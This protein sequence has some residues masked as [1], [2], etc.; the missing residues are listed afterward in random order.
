M[1][2]YAPRPSSTPFTIEE[3][4]SSV[5]ISEE[6]SFA[7]SVPLP[8]ATPVFAS[9]RAGLSFTPSPVT[10]TNSPNLL[11]EETISSFCIGVTRLYTFLVFMYSSKVLWSF[12]RNLD[13]SSPVDSSVSFEQIP[14]ARAIL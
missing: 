11:Y 14:R 4:L 5:M 12:F 1:L 13:N 10:V 7:M 3:N 2:S 8:M 9:F 6:V